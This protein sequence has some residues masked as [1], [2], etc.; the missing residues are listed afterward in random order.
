[1]NT[2]SPHT[3]DKLRIAELQLCD[4]IYGY[5]AGQ[6]PVTTIQLTSATNRLLRDIQRAFRKA[7]TDF[8]FTP[9]K[10]DEKRSRNPRMAD[11]NKHNRLLGSF[12][13][14][15]DKGTVLDSAPYT[16][17]DA[18][19]ALFVTAKDFKAISRNLVKQG[20]ATADGVTRLTTNLG[21][22]SRSDLLI[23][24]FL[25]FATAKKPPVEGLRHLAA[26]VLKEGDFVPNPKKIQFNF[27]GASGDLNAEKAE[28]FDLILKSGLNAAP[29]D[30][31]GL[32]LVNA[33]QPNTLRQII[34][35]PIDL[36]NKLRAFLNQR[37]P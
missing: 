36:P 37:E 35:L 20:L 23:G 7:N 14:H 19:S 29:K 28:I 17:A 3:V 34:D 6:S 33:K 15:A 32:R 31:I 26:V 16:D 4:A 25:E 10:S 9:L 5:F 2:V 12:A 21:A 18:R 13:R 27:M 1:M 8:Q 22:G 11:V 30:E 24:I